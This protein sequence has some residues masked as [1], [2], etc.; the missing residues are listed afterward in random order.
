M[1]H[2]ILQAGFPVVAHDL[3]NKAVDDLVS[4]GAEKATSAIEIAERSDVIVVCVVNDEQVL[5]VVKTM[6]PSLQPDSV[7]IVTSS[8]RPGTIREA[9]FHVNRAHSELLD[10]AVSGSRPR[11]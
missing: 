9:A 4:L 8:V 10:A 2:R 7:V 11:C 5:D 6:E 3:R 1:A